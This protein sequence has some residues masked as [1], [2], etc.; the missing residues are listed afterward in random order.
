[1]S[2]HTNFKDKGSGETSKYSLI[3]KQAL[4][5]V[6]SNVYCNTNTIY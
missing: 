2:E 5:H 1:M 4:T 3:E 6:S